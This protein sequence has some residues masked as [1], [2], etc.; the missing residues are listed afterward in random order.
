[1]L[2]QWERS[3]WPR[4]SATSS[5]PYGTS[6]LRTLEH[7]P[8]PPA[9]SRK[10]AELGSAPVGPIKVV[11]GYLSHR[12]RSPGFDR[13]VRRTVR[14]KR[15][16]SVCQDKTAGLTSLDTLSQIAGETGDAEF[17]VATFRC[18][19][20]EDSNLCA[21]RNQSRADAQPE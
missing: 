11:R 14:K 21:R 1:M 17:L 10:Q 16:Q 5:R 13:L 19:T 4:G 8:S 12:P 15:A 6:R 9:K 3:S 20:S 7:A 2:G 18:E